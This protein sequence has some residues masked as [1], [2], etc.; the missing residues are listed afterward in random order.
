MPLF[1]RKDDARTLPKG[2]DSDKTLTSAL[3]S[4]RDQEK[5]HDAQF[6]WFHYKTNRN[7]AENKLKKGINS[8]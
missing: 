7:L 8:R 1:R 3:Q 4:D 6:C 2:L 5:K